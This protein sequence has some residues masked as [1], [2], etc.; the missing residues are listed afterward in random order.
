MSDRRDDDTKVRM[1]RLIDVNPAISQREIAQQLGLSVGKV[2]YLINAL[3]DRGIVKARNFRRSGNKSAYAYYLTPAG[4]FDKAILTHQFLA[5][6]L[7]EYDA[8]RA[9]IAALQNEVSSEFRGE[10][11]AGSAAATGQ[12]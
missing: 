8:L 10:A 2:N 7:I 6:K 1:M 4:L 12:A 9:E 3:I 5:R 11:A